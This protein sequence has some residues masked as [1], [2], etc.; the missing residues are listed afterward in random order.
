MA[1]VERTA[2]SISWTNLGNLGTD[3]ANLRAVIASG[4]TINA[5][6]INSLSTLMNWAMGHY[7]TYDDA[8]Q[9]ATYGNTGDRNNYYR[10]TSTGSPANR[11]GDLGGVSAG[12][13]ITAS[14]H[15]EMRNRAEF[16]RFHYHQVDDRTA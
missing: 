1:T 15:N 2:K 14:H 16:L 11:P 9:L 12:S 8:Y 10:D 4:Q 7:H 3:I 5:S 6:N 13:D